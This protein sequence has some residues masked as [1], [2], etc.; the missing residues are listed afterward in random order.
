MNISASKPGYPSKP[1]MGG[2]LTYPFRE[3]SVP[4]QCQNDSRDLILQHC[5]NISSGIIVEIGVFG[6]ASL[7][8]IVDSAIAND[9]QLFGIDPFESISIFNGKIESEIPQ[10]IVLDSR[11]LLKNNRLNLENIIDKCNLPIKLLV[12]ESYNMVNHFDDHS[13]DV[14]HIDGD[15]STDGVY[16]DF[17]KFFPKMKS[18]GL[19]IGDDYTWPSVKVGIDNFCDEFGL[20]LIKPGQYGKV[21]IYV[22]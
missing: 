15:H 21:L 4:T 14:I 2:F 7:L 17:K 13:I 10:S 22:P 19:M 3:F 20:K 16:D 18:G 6:G 9:N 12:G 1:N 11:N 5:K 8:H